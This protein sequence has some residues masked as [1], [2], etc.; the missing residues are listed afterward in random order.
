MPFRVWCVL[1]VVWWD[2]REEKQGKKNHNWTKPRL[3]L[4]HNEWITT[5]ETGM[6]YGGGGD[7]CVFICVCLCGC[8][9]VYV[10]IPPPHLFLLCPIFDPLEENCFFWEEGK[11]DVK[12]NDFI[13]VC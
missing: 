11:C 2:G 13:C 1:C 7:V 6:G 12:K 5:G 9:C 3:L 10:Y 4:Y 8:M